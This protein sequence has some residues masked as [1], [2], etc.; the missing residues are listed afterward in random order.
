MAKVEGGDL[1]LFYDGKSIAYATNHTLSISGETQDTSNKDEGGGGWASE[2]VSILSWTVSSD[3]LYS[4]DGEGNNFED[5]FDL[6]VAK[7]PITAVF[8]KKAETAVDVPTGGWTPKS[9]SGYTG[10]VVI[11]SLEL[12]APNGEKATYTVQFNGVG[13]LT[14]IS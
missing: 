10:Q 5:L 3:N 4:E 7:Q 11:T 8:A 2:E 9:N 12:N 13:A 1:M 6:M 14:K